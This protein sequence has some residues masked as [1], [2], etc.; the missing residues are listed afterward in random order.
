MFPIPRCVWYSTC[1]C[2][3][4]CCSRAYVACRDRWCW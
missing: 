2:A 3:C 1:A 4:V